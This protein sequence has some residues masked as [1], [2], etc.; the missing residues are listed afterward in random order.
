MKKINYLTIFLKNGKTLRF[1][2]VENFSADESIITF[3]Y[4]SASTGRKL[5]GIFI[6]ENIA[7]SSMT[8]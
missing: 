2:E 8:I 7:G 3:N 6:I 5:E 1:E 4:I